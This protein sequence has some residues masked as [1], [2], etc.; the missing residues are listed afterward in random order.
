MKI[1]P[2][3]GKFRSV[4]CLNGDLPKKELFDAL[5]L[6]IIPADCAYNVLRAKQI[7]AEVVIGDLDSVEDEVLPETQ[8]IYIENQDQSDFQKALQYVRERQ[9]EPS[10]ILGINGGYIDHIFNNIAVFSQTNGV[11]YMP[12]NLGITIRE[13]R[14]LHFAKGTKISLFAMPMCRLTTHGL[15]WELDNKIFKFPHFSSCF[16]RCSTG[17]LKISIGE[18]AIFAVVYLED[19]IDAGKK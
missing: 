16:N 12:P 14:T 5:R 1:L 19:I 15:F 8:R 11:S 6:P 3:L 17:A 10:I 13:N 2:T 18:G 7:K 4:I 9:L